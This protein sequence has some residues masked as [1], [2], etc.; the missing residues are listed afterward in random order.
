MITKGNS[1]SKNIEWD[2]LLD[3]STANEW[4]TFFM[5]LYG[6][7]ELR[8]QRLL[9]P[10]NAVGKPTLIIFSG[11]ILHAYG[12]CA[13]VRWQVD[14]NRFLASLIIAKNTIAPTRQLSIPSLELC[15]TLM[16]ASLRETIIKEHNWEFD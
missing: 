10:G 12:A 5:N 1:T 13:Y 3:V 7:E 15:G 14:E 16:L 9:I 11:G 6:L 4:K 8:F 2:D